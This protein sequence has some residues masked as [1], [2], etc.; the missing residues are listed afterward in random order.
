MYMINVAY[1]IIIIFR[2]GRIVCWKGHIQL[3]KYLKRW[4]ALI[5]RSKQNAES[6]VEIARLRNALCNMKA[7]LHDLTNKEE[8]AASLAAERALNR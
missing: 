2:F 8:I 7:T 3:R 1:F 5:Q 4:E 6:G